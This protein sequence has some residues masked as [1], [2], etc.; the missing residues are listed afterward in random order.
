MPRKDLELRKEYNREYSKEYRK[1]NRY[2]DRERMR[3]W[4]TK[5]RD[6]VNAYHRAWNRKNREKVNRKRREYC[7]RNYKEWTAYFTEIHGVLP[8][9]QICNQKLTWKRN[10]GNPV[11][12]DHRHGTRS[13]NPSDWVRRHSLNDKNKQ[14][15]ESFDYGI[16]CKSC[17]T[18]LP[19]DNRTRWLKRVVEYDKTKTSSGS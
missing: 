12:W 6:E 19:T 1:K 2:K 11:V 18:K 3:L 8:S 13:E 15:W 17:N 7:E 10:E 5:N 4:R 14:I 16:L 9:C